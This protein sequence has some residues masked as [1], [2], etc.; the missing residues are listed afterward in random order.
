M[1]SR[2][3][4]LKNLTRSQARAQA[5]LTPTPRETLDGIPAVPQLRAHLD[6]GPVT[7]GAAPSR[8]EGRVPRTSSSFSGV[9]VAF[10]G[11][12]WTTP[13]GPVVD[14]AEEE[15]N[16]VDEDEDDSTEAVHTPVGASQG[17]GGS[18]LAN[19]NHPEPSLLSIMKQMI[20]I[21]ANIQAASF[22]EAS[23]PPAFQNPSMKAPDCFDGTEPFKVRSFIQ[24]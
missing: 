8:K 23:I 1:T 11:I 22:S 10:P 18:T 15:G 17:T 4:N 19:Y 5:F 13:T 20:Q 16:Y 24:S 14:D 9:V 2:L 12:S 7:E 3:I 6:R 21:L